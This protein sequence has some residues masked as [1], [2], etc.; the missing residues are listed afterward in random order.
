M[1]A[2]T[3]CD[4]TDLAFVNARMAALKDQ[5]NEI[6]ERSGMFGRDSEE[7]HARYEELSGE[8]GRLLGVKMDLEAEQQRQ[9]YLAKRR[10]RRPYGGWLAPLVNRIIPRER[11][12]YV[13]QVSLS[14]GEFT[15]LPS[16]RFTAGLTAAVAI[17]ANVVIAL[18]FPWLSIIPF[19]VV[20]DLLRGA[21]VPLLLAYLL[22]VAIYC[23]AY[24]TA[25]VNGSGVAPGYA[26]KTVDLW[27]ANEEQWFRQGAQH[28]SGWLRFRSCVGFGLAHIGNMVYPVTW[29]LT[30]IP[31]GAVF[32][33]VYLRNYAR[34]GGSEETAVLAATKFHAMVNR[35]LWSYV[36]LTA[37]GYGIYLL[38]NLFL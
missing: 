22:A 19:R 26:T 25:S 4:E 5:I 16:Y 8:W 6:E 38:I 35:F 10:Y 15:D 33:Y 1:N 11:E 23:A 17:G 2:D 24:M 29:I 21:N 18:A 31:L 30:T 9:Q 3:P 27:A 32:M 13:G 36:G 14:I 20:M 7:D 34:S 28:W 12:E 37:A